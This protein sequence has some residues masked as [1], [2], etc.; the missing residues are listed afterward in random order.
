[1]LQRTQKQVQPSTANTEVMLCAGNC[2]LTSALPQWQQ[3]RLPHL[4]GPHLQ[5]SPQLCK[6]GLELTCIK[7][8]TRQG[9]EQTARYQAD[10]CKGGL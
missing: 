9:G 10:K 6:L 8:V 3:R 7:K 5:L 4:G 1:L 2:V